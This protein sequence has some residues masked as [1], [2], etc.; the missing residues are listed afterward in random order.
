MAALAARGVREDCARQ[1]LLNLSDERAAKDQIEWGDS[2]I[3]RKQRS[4]DPI[5][6][7]AGFYVY[8]L[9]S[10]YP[11]PPDFE[12]SRKRQLREDARQRDM[13]ARARQAR[14]E[15]DSFER[16]ERYEAWVIEETERYLKTRVPTEMQARRLREQMRRIQQEASQYSWPETA[17]REFARRK[18]REEVA[19]EMELPSFEEFQ[20]REDGKLF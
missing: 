19:A 2:E 8:L 16:H 12:S 18:L 9:R 3:A 1:I 20:Q 10:N 6:N 14:E 17:L 15:L 7:P 5:S 4:R 13:D 11:V